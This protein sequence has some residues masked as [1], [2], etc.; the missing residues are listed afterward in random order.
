MEGL[1]SMLLF[2]GLFFVVMRFGCGAHM[3]HGN[4][5]SHDYDKKN[6]NQQ[7]YIDPVC[8]MEVDIELGYGKMH[9]GNLYRFCSRD[10]LDKFETDP[11]QYI[12]NKRHG[13]YHR[14]GGAL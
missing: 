9:D 3:M 13:E 14:E 6:K 1:L 4:H 12:K 5:G 10:C 2:A 7:R 11:G 8:G